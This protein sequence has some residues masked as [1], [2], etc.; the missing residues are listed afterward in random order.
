MTLSNLKRHFH[1]PSFVLFHFE[2]PL[3][4]FWQ[5]SSRDGIFQFKWSSSDNQSQSE[6]LCHAGRNHCVSWIL[7]ISRNSWCKTDTTG[8]S[9][10]LFSTQTDNL[11]DCETVDTDYILHADSNHDVLQSIINS[12]FLIVNI[13]AFYLPELELFVNVTAL[14]AGC[15]QLR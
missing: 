8:H 2:W 7:C 1:I 12:L 15:R 9:F 5:F 6:R 13:L 3:S 11:S 14:S 10:Q 4:D